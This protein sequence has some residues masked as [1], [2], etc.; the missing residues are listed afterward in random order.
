MSSATDTQATS[1]SS[2]GTTLQG[3]WRWLLAA[4]AI[5]AVLGIIALFAPFVTGVSLTFVVGVLLIAGG[6]L[7]FISA[8]RAQGWGGFAWQMLLGFVAVIAGLALILNPVLGL[9]TLTILVIAYLFVSGIVEIIMGISL[10]GER[11]WFVSIASGAIGILLA[12]LLW[13]GFPSTAAWAVGVL[14][15]VNLLVS[16]I[17]MVFIALGARREMQPVEFD[18]P[19]EAGGA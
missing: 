11:N 5:I 16:G 4:G 15:G 2:L 14:F 12:A 18:Q 9:F 8:F 19:A 7:H 3:S 1:D 13:V 6:I 10:R 17:S